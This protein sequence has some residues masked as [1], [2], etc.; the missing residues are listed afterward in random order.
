MRWIQ[1]RAPIYKLA[2]YFN[3]NEIDDFWLPYILHPQCDLISQPVK[4]FDIKQ[5]G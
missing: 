2:K 1:L 3:P 5:T 4:I